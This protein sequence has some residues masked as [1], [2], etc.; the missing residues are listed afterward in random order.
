MH[1]DLYQQN[2][3]AVAD[4]LYLVPKVHRMMDLHAQTL[5]ELAAGLETAEFTSVELTQALLDRIARHNDELNAFVTVTAER[6]ARGRS[7]CR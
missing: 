1:R 7:A 6:S 3:A 2:A 4:G 5:T